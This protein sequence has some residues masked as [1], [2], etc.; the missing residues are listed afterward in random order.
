MTPS[1]PVSG[2]AITVLFLGVLGLVLSWFFGL[3]L[4]PAVVALVLARRAR[5]EIAASSGGSTGLGLVSAGCVCSWVAVAISTLYL[6]YILFVV[7][8]S[9]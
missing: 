6:S 1:S 3:G 4:V 9:L 7:V 2:K 8:G 5:R